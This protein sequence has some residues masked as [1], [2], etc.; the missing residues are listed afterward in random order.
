MQKEELVKRAAKKYNLPIG[1]TAKATN[2]I[3]AQISDEVANGNK[4]TL[5]GFGTFDKTWHRDRVGIN[6]QTKKPLKIP[7][8]YAVNFKAGKAFKSKINESNDSKKED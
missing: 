8:H 2:A 4:I 3:F 1:L 6:P 5:M 7:A